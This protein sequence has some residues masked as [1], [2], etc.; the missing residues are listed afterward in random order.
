MWTLKQ[1]EA[2]NLYNV[3]C[4]LHAPHGWHNIDRSPN[5]LL[6]RVRP[7]KRL[8]RQAGVLNDAH[9]AAWPRNIR[10]LDVR[11]GLPCADGQA[12][13]IYSSHM[14]E[15]LYLDEACKVISACYR[16][17]RT[18]AVFR[19]A[20]P[21]G[22]EIALK[23]AEDTPEAFLDYN[24]GLLAH[25]LLAPN[26]RQRLVGFLKSPPHRWQPSPS[27]VIRLFQEAG[28]AAPVEREYLKS[29]LPRVEEVEHRPESFFVEATK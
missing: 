11:K 5:L 25:P 17:L 2:L 10:M 7:L 16:A 12:D 14:L 26:A 6:D 13:G 8:L 24:E 19:V 4:G 3:G 21:N 28:F 9:M 1:G 15:H 22:H 20:L 23:G 27:L 18:G 29:G